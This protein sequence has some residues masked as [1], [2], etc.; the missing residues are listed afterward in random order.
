MGLTLQIR[1]DGRPAPQL[2]ARWQR[3]E[4]RHRLG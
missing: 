1:V 4:V 2:A 3:L